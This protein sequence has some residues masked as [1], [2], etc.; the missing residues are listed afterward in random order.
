ML[1]DC[2]FIVVKKEFTKVLLIGVSLVGAAGLTFLSQIVF[3][4]SLSAED[5]GSLVAAFAIIR[6]LSPLAGFGIG[7]YWLAKFG[8]EG[9]NARAWL[10]S[11]IRTMSLTIAIALGLGVLWASIGAS[12][13]STT[14]AVLCTLPMVVF[15]ALSS[16]AVSRY[17]LEERYR[18]ISLWAALPHLPRA[19]IAGLAAMLY[20]ELKDVLGLLFAAYMLLCIVPVLVVRGMSGER[21]NLVGHGERPDM[22]KSNGRTRLRDVI[23][24]A[25]WYGLSGAFYLIHYQGMIILL[26]SLDGR[27]SAAEYGVAFTVLAAVFI[28]PTVLYRWYMMPKMHRWAWNDGN[29]LL[30][31]Y[32]KTFLFIVAVGMLLAVLIVVSAPYGIPVL[33]GQRYAASTEVIQLLSIAVIL[34]FISV[35]QGSLLVSTG[36]VR[37]KVFI[38]AYC[39]FFGV[40]VGILCIKLYGIYGAVLAT[41]L[42]ELSLVLLYSSKIRRTGNIQY[43]R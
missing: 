9:W 15:Q 14:L 39:A 26:E 34:R 8:S 21:F 23:V 41:N 38:D 43:S 32:R 22:S 24:D 5:F 6:I 36:F 35:A 27:N 10:S 40:M 4:R 19:T 33:F 13:K 28:I 11:S 30:D 1:S 17:Q 18:S 7:E 25:K 31:V 2:K 29:K 16:L 12:S 42:T 37:S 3:A 20:L